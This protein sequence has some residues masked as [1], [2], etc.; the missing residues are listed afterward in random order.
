MNNTPI[1]RLTT[2]YPDSDNKPQNDN[3]QVF[4]RARPLNAKELSLISSKK[5][6]NIIKKQENMVNSFNFL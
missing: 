1:S 2:P 3:F 5:K 4:V 6:P